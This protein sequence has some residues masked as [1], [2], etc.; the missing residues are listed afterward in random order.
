MLRVP[1]SVNSKNRQT[2]RIIQK[3][4]GYRP[5]IKLLLEDFYIYLSGQR[6]ADLEQK[7]SRKFTNDDFLESSR[8][9]G[10]I[11]IQWIERLLQTS[12][13]DFRKLAIW[14]VLAPYLLNIR[15]L[16]PDE[17]HGIVYEWLDK[18][19]QLRRLDFNPTYRIK[20]VLNN[21]KGFLPVSC[22]CVKEERN[23]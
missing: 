5:S 6:L 9:D 14:R 4:N 21:S 13:S 18:C 2:V 3:W 11:S 23:D 20:G 1:G 22:V 17:A 8:L 10:C 16:S 19:S 12:L 15:N 7:I